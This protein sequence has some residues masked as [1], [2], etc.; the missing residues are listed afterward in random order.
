MTNESS[1]IGLVNGVINFIGLDSR[2]HPQRRPIVKLLRVELT[3]ML[4][5]ILIVL[6]FSAAIWQTLKSNA[7]EI[8]VLHSF[9]R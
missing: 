1:R 9:D 7:S 5:G 3:C 8:K 4:Q 6:K 2:I